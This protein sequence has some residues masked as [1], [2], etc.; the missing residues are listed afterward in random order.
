MRHLA[1]SADA[2]TDAVKTILRQYVAGLAAGDFNRYAVIEQNRV[3]QQDLLAQSYG[4][5]AQA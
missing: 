1:K 4:Q 3:Q 5:I 2:A